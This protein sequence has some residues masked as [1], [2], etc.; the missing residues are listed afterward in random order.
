MSYMAED[1]CQS[2]W[3]A[4]LISHLGIIGLAGL[5]QFLPSRIDVDRTQMAMLKLDGAI[6]LADG[7]R[8]WIRDAAWQS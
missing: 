7:R 5:S 2:I 4:A 1:R 3:M 6:I 8:S